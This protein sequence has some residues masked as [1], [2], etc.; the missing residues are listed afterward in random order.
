MEKKLNFRLSLELLKALDE[1]RR[2]E[3]DLPSRGEMVRRLI[4]RAAAAKAAKPRGKKES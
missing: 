2:A 4:T 3:E 1:L